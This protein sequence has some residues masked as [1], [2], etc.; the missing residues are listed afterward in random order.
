MAEESNYKDEEVR[1]ILD[2]ALARSGDAS[3]G[4]SHAEL[5][6][7]AAE[8]GVAQGAVETA[9]AEVLD[10]RR[11]AAARAA[12]TAGR[13]R[14]L[15]LHAL[16]FAIINGLLFAVNALTTPGEWWVLFSVVFWGLALALHAGLAAFVGISPGALEREKR[17]LAELA[18]RARVSDTALARERGAA[19]VDVGEQGDP[20]A[21]IR[22]GEAGEQS[23][24]NEA[25]RPRVER[26]R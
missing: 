9:A 22:P 18:P 16:V 3:G 23:A 4:L 12:L 20:T 11:T 14:W 13:R 6:S 17:R 15:G 10:E 25:E 1:A 24:L 8:V 5:V 7:V 19:R 2:R 26:K 21:Q